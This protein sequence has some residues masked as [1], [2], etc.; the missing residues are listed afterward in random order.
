MFIP[1][2]AAKRSKSPGGFDFPR[3]LAAAQTRLGSDS[4]QDCHSPPC[5]R[6]ATLETTERGTLVSL[7]LG[8]TSAL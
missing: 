3:L 6:Y 8:H 2:F 1:S 4:L 7:R 5:R